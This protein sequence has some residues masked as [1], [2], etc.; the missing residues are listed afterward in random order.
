M[1]SN[2]T[3]NYG[4]C[5][6]EA[7]DQVLREEFNQNNAQL[8]MALAQLKQPMF[9]IAILKDYDGS[10]DV[11]VELGHQPAMV[12]VGNR[13]GWTNII[14]TS[15]TTNHPAHAVALPDYPGY[16]SGSSA[17]TGAKIILEVTVSGFIVHSG[18]DG[19]LAPFY[20]LAFF[21]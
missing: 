6:W 7:T 5:Q 17:S 8:D 14:T 13:L 1:A 4:L 18:F 19:K 11:T 9:K 21:E 10:S 20:Y 3:E 12:I 16:Q 2:Y 15:S